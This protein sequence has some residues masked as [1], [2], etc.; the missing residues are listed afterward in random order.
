MPRTSLVTKESTLG[1]QADDATCQEYYLNGWRIVYHKDQQAQR[2]NTPKAS[3]RY[4]N[5][6]LTFKGPSLDSQMIKKEPIKLSQ[7]PKVPTW[8]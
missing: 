2:K 7:L 5:P 8:W 4:Q 6:H 3:S 1:L